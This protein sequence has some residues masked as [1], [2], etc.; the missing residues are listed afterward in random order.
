MPCQRTGPRLDVGGLILEH[1][2]DSEPPR[3]T[4]LGH[5]ARQPTHRLPPSHLADSH[6]PTVAILSLIAANCSSSTLMDSH[7]PCHDDPHG[8]L[9]AFV[10]QIPL[11]KYFALLDFPPAWFLCVLL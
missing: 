4:I 6:P 3:C 11:T 10:S 5:P 1:L 2:S 8:R 7:R 9:Y